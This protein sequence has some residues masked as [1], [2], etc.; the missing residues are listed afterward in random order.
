MAI[1]GPFTR[2]LTFGFSERLFNFILVPLDG[3]LNRYLTD[4]YTKEQQMRQQA[5]TQQNPS[6]TT[7]L[8]QG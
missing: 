5:V 7:A 1:I 2:I 6:P 4:R 8:S 3:I